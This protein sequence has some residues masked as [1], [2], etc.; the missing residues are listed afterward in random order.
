MLTVRD[1]SVRYGRFTALDGVDWRVGTDESMV[2][3]LLGPS[4]CGKTTLLR[5][6]AGFEPL[7]SGSVSWAGHDVSST[8]AHRR[9]FGVVFQDGQL[10]PGRTVAQNVAYGL[11][12]RGVGRTVIGA[13]VDEMLELVQLSGFGDRSVAALSGGQ[14]QRVALARAL[15]PRPR[16]LLLDEPLAA[17]DAQLRESLAEAIGTIVR[18]SGTP[19][20]LVTHDHREAALMADTVSVMSAGRIVQSDE[21][22]RLWHRPADE[23][24]ARF[25]GA[26]AFVDGSVAGATLRTPLGD[27]LRGAQGVSG[28]VFD[29]LVD[30]P[31]RVALRPESIVAWPAADGASAAGLPAGVG[32]RATVVHSA[33]LV[34]GWR[35][36]VRI[37]AQGAG[38]GESGAAEFETGESG[39]AEFDAVSAVA[40]A[41]G[42]SVRL[43]LDPGALAVVGS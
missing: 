9:D 42:H 30:G 4:G 37:G 18:R 26:R 12:R 34:S 28:G 2:T 5:A 19:T 20:V 3:A 35:L 24:T 36:R 14:A 7:A 17:L 33:A 11:R 1:V 10:F 15:A 43:R 39:A 27:V 40:V 23:E 38:A 41:P 32:P 25:L 21:T 29:D 22:S 16:L 31:V 6:I 8:A 13:R